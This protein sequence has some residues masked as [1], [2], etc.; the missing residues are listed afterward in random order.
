MSL[1]QIVY[2]RNFKYFNIEKF[3]VVVPYVEKGLPE[4]R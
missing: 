4:I 3:Q 1:I 2:L